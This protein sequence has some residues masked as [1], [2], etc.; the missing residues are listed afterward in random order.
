LPGGLL[1][2]TIGVVVLAVS[3]VMTLVGDNG[4]IRYRVDLH[5]HNQTVGH[6]TKAWCSSVVSAVRARA[7]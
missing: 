6:N 2:S 1:K 7:F 4:S 3:R 5:L